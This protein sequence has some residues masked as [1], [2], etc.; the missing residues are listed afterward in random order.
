MHATRVSET[1]GRVSVLEPRMPREALTS[2]R[3]AE[4]ERAIAAAFSPHAPISEG[5][6]FRGRTDQIR[7]IIDTLQAPGLHAAIYGERG[8]GKTS[9]AT[10][11]K[12][13]FAGLTSIVRVSCGRND[14]FA[15]VIRRS[16]EQIPISSSTRPAGLVP[17]PASRAGTLD[18]LLGDSIDPDSVARILA[19]MPPFVLIVID[20][21]DRLKRKQTAAFADLVKALSDRGSDATLVL[22]GVAQDINALIDSHSSVER[23]LRQVPL[24]RMSDLELRE[25]IDGGIGATGLTLESDAPRRRIL[26]VSQGF[27]HYTHLLSQNA[28]RAAVDDGRTVIADGD[29][30]RGMHTAVERADQSHRELYYRAVTAT[31][32]QNLWKE[33]TAAC[34]L[35]PPDERGYFSSGAVQ[36]KLSE[37]LGRKIIQQTLAYHLGKMI[38]ASRGPLLERIGPERRYR[39]RF[40]NPLMRPFIT[41][42]AMNDGLIKPD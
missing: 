24:Q 26:S 15:S 14:T 22:V 11:I 40:I 4:L 2:E 8:V 27:P 16:F 35:A 31:K 13:F 17:R 38:E 12:D 33:V 6:L 23:C 41:M 36:D 1:C 28:A 34:A 7:A 42:K 30:V 18:V 3:R 25:I 19:S 10:I 39:Y 5:R 37:I 29:V 21:L 32:K 9:L 20:E